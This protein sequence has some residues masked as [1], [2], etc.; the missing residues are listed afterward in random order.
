MPDQ[1]PGD[2]FS[3][4]TRKSKAP[5]TKTRP[6][7]ATTAAAIVRGAPKQAEPAPTMMRT[8]DDE[9][10][11]LD[12]APLIP[13]DPHPIPSESDRE[14][15]CER[16]DAGYWLDGLRDYLKV[17]TA[18]ERHAEP[19]D[20]RLRPRLLDFGCASGRVL[21]HVACQQDRAEPWGC[22]IARNNVEWIA[23]H[24]P[25]SIRV[26]QNTIFP[27]LP[28]EDAFFD[29]ICAFSV[30]THIDD[31]EDLWLL[32]LRR[33]LRPGGIAFLTIHSERSWLRVRQLPWVLH[34]M[35]K[36]RAGLPDPMSSETMFERPLPAER[37]VLRGT[38][39]EVYRCNVFVSQDY[40]RKRWSRWLELCAIYD[41][42]IEGFQD[43]VVLRRGS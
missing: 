3:L 14:F 35:L 29:V 2:I 34:D 15:Y 7:I 8:L 36:C 42:G 10:V 21:R 9:A 19:G 13:L 24:L 27:H 4:L 12:V 23:T 33:V 41:G 18:V 38:G 16:N 11:P 39:D 28:V 40:V 26:F 31:F 17:K 1:E 20:L 37:V 43:I 22:D 6:P 25:R 30:F 32:E 5:E